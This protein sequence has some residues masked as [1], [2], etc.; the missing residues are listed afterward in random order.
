VDN[1]GYMDSNALFLLQNW[2]SLGF[3][4]KFFTEMILDIL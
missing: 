4:C 1:R 3:S 2:Q